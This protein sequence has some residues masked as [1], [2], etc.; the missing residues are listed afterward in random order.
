[1]NVTCQEIY[2]RMLVMQ[3]MHIQHCR[4]M[5]WSMIPFNLPLEDKFVV[6]L[7]SLTLS[8]CLSTMRLKL[9]E[10][11]NYEEKIHVD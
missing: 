3:Y 5:V 11:V 10:C 2:F 4:Y 8:S 6:P 7:D 1:M 9:L